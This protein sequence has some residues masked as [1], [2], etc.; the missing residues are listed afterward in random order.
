MAE[1]VGVDILFAPI[2]EQMYGP[3]FQTRLQVEKL[4]LGLCGASRPGHFD[5]VAT[6]VTKLFLAAKPHVA[7]FGQKD[8]QQLA[9][10]RQLVEDL[11]FD[12]EIIG[13]PIVRE[14]DGLAMSSRNTYLDGRERAIAVCLYQ[15]IG[16]ARQYCAAATGPVEIS[17][18]EQLVRSMIEVNEEC[19]VDYVKVVDGRTLESQSSTDKNSMLILAVKINNRVRLIDNSPLY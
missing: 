19:R 16:R 9:V 8:F 1:S 7:V 13:H 3:R 12:I 11:N 2:P 6:V 4:S 10:I 5:G 18:V 15:S 14:A 17:E